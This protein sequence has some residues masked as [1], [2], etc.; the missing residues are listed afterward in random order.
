MNTFYS[1]NEQ[2]IYPHVES[3]CSKIHQDKHELYID[4]AL[5][6]P[7]DEKFLPGTISSSFC[8]FLTSLDQSSEK[9][10]L[11]CTKTSEM[12]AHNSTLTMSTFG[13]LEF[14]SAL[15][16]LQKHSLL[17]AIV[18]QDVL[19]VLIQKLDWH[20]FVDESTWTLKSGL[21]TNYFGVAFRVALLREQLGWDPE[22]A[23][24]I[25]LDILTKHIVDHSGQYLY[26]DETNGEGRF[27]KYTVS[28]AAELCELLV[29]FNKPIPD[30]LRQ[31]MQKCCDI[32]I[33]LLDVKG[34]GFCY[35]RSIGSH[36]EAIIIETFPV[37][38]RM[39]LFSDEELPF[40]Y[41]ATYLAAH[42]ITSFWYKDCRGGFNIWDDGRRTDH[43]RGKMRVLE[44]NLDMSLKM[45]RAERHLKAAKLSHTPI[46]S[47]AVY[48]VW[49]DKLPKIKYFWFE[50]ET[51]ERGLLI[52]RTP[53]H[54]FSLPLINGGHTHYSHTAYLPIPYAIGIIEGTPDESRPFLVP[55]LTL[56]D[57]HKLMPLSYMKD[58]IIDESTRQISF[59]Q[60]V[61]CSL[62]DKGCPHPFKGISCI[63]TYTFE[64][65]NI[66]RKDEFTV[67][68]ELKVTKVSL[69]LDTFSSLISQGTHTL[70]LEGEL[71]HFNISG[72]NI[73]HTEDVS[74]NPTY[75]TPHGAHQLNVKCEGTP[76]SSTFTTSWSFNYN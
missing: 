22:G 59:K 35:G 46:L 33:Q 36:G 9:F 15:Y 34:N 13:I 42:K 18:S 61:L 63:T 60:D 66:S 70:S 27:D 75:N 14:L 50:K 74:N 45:L 55:E 57:G 38:I 67:D 30:I 17:A 5:A 29:E 8:Y 47:A 1:L 4:G 10:Q 12:I 40:I 28:I 62:E 44:V 53:N 20:V 43:Y 56:E 11:W 52:V 19:D 31:I 41:T 65:N 3:L 69:E 26:M 37:A 71:S 32:L 6:F 58:I 73:I 23:S 51:Y 49:L 24:T 72:L 76:S 48:Q 2:I 64:E 54:I 39:G 25:L 7:K 16:E 21:P 68:S